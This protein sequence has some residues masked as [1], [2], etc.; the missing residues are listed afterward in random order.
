MQTPAFLWLELQ[1]AQQCLPENFSQS[2]APRNLN[3]PSRVRGAAAHLL[4]RYSCLYTRMYDRFYYGM[5]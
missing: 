4:G 5:Q 1:V 2:R 3:S